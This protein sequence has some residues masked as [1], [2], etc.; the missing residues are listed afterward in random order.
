MEKRKLI[1][2]I[3]TGIL[4]IILIFMVNN[5]RKRVSEA[6][7]LRTKHKVTVMKDGEVAQAPA[8]EDGGF[9]GRKIYAGKGLYRGLE[10]ECR[11]MGL[12]RDPFYAGAIDT[13]TGAMTGLRLTGILW[14]DIDPLAIIDDNPVGAGTMIDKYT[15]LKIEKDKVILTDGTKNYTLT[16]PY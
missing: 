16:L 7:R 12:K 15:V 10:D 5:A 1:Q 9:V 4:V 11:D 3:I 6:K 8:F 14:D 13:T 2:L